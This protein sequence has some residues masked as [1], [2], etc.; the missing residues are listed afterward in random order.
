LNKILNSHKFRCFLGILILKLQ[1][2]PRSIFRKFTDTAE[3]K[4]HVNA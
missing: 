1:E 3:Q 4:N 2:T